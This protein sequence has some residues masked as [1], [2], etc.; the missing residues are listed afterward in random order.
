[1]ASEACMPLAIEHA[2]EGIKFVQTCL[3]CPEQYDAFDGRGR[4]VG[5]LRLRFGRFTVSYPCVTGDVV[6]EHR[7]EGDGYKGIFDND[8]ERGMYLTIAA[9]A[10]KKARRWRA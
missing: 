10:L 5:Y 1:M 9:R 4:V 3:G 6:F 7:F 2:I 8:E